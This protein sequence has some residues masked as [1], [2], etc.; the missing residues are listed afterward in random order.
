MRA[1]RLDRRIIIQENTPTQNGVGSEV[2]SW[3]DLYVVWA[4]V[5]PVRGTER[6]AGSQDAAVIEEKF[7]IRYLK[8][9]TPKNRILYNGRIYDI[10]GAPLEI[11]RREGLEIQAKARAD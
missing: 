11:G 5:I 7:K 2:D 4:E 9:I 10:K 6:Y 3:S 8:G 1:G